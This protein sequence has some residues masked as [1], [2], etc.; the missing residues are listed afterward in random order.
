[1]RY[2]LL[3]LPLLA[4]AAPAYAQLLPV[5]GARNLDWSL[6]PPGGKAYTV[7][8][9]AA[10]GTDQMPIAGSGRAEA[11]P[12]VLQHSLSGVG[13]HY[14]DPTRRLDYEWPG[15]GPDSLITV[16]EP[17]TGRRY[18]YRRVGPPE[19]YQGPRLL[20]RPKESSK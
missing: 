20:W 8:L 18:T 10:G 4:V 12:N 17:V 14:W 11:M 19:F 9:P 3:T 6:E 1:M 5:P 7:K 13:R 16:R 15:S 2:L